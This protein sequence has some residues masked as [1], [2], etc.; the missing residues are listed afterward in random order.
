MMHLAEGYKQLDL[1]HQQQHSSLA[2]LEAHA[3]SIDNV[4]AEKLQ[5]LSDE[6][7]ILQR[8]SQHTHG[9]VPLARAT[10]V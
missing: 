10:G 4:H 1:L 8:S 9:Y 5:A 3:A 7:G 6:I 2:D